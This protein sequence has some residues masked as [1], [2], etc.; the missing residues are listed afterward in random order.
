MPGRATQPG[1]LQNR[2][3][4]LPLLQVD[5]VVTGSVELC[6]NSQSKL[7]RAEIVP[8]LAAYPD[9]RSLAMI[10]DSSKSAQKTSR[11]AVTATPEQACS[12]ELE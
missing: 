2:T 9:R 11:Q 4:A 3:L 5:K 1:R 6:V 12:V 7:E 8:A 10:A